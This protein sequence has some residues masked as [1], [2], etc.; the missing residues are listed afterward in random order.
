MCYHAEFGSS[1]SRGVIIHVIRVKPK[2]WGTLELRPLRI[3][4][5][6]GGISEI[7][8]NVTGKSHFSH[9]LYF[10]MWLPFAVIYK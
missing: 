2:N 6:A 1:T 9:P 7:N 4:G 3:G 10:Y 8:G 5:V